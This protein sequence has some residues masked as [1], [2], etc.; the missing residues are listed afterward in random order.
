DGCDYAGTRYFDKHNNP[1]NDPSL[2]ECP[3]TLTACKLRH[4]EGNELPF[5]GFPGTSLI[6]S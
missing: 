5:G 1:V 6:R 4:G 3:G 2:D